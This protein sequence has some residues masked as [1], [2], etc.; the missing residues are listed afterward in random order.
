MLIPGER[1][2][3]MQIMYLTAVCNGSSL[4][5]SK[6]ASGLFA[7]LPILVLECRLSEVIA[8][9]KCQLMF[10]TGRCLKLMGQ[11]NETEELFLSVENVLG[12]IMWVIILNPSNDIPFV[13]DSFK[14][15]L[16]LF[17]YNLVHKS[18]NQLIIFISE[19]VMILIKAHTGY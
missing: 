8:T 15:P 2:T 7:V 4:F 16:H 18:R 3:E 9:D 1:N 17:L 6:C 10:F 19:E 11:T 14:Y 12:Q 13:L 5:L